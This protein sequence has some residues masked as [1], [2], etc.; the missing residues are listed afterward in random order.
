MVAQMVDGHER[1]GHKDTPLQWAMRWN[2]GF[3]I[4][5]NSTASIISKVTKALLACGA[6]AG[7]LFTVA[8]IV[9]G[10][11]RANYDPLRHPIS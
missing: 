4:K 1:G 2:E 5:N 11:T 6:V 7:P 3:M 9:T 8:W 10:A